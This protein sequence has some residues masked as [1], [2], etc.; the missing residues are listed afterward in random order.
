MHALPHADTITLSHSNLFVEAGIEVSSFS[1]VWGA[2]N[3]SFSACGA[4]VAGTVRMTDVYWDKA[5]S[6]VLSR[7]NAWVR[8]RAGI[9]ELKVGTLARA[10]C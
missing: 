3:G 1:S 2:E 7:A 8:Q 6:Y 10:A 4:C 9:W 5:P